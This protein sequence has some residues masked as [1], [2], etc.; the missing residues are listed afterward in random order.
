[1]TVRGE[2]LA[3]GICFII[4]VAYSVAAGMWAVLWTDLVQFVI[5]M[6]A[7]I[8]LA[9]FAVRAVGG[10]DVM[11]V[12]SWRT[13]AAEKRRS[14]CCRCSLGPPSACTAYAWMPLLT[15]GVYLSVQWWAAWYPGAEPGGGG[16]IAQR[17]FSAKTERDGVL[18]TL[19]FNIAHYA[20]RPWP[21]IVTGTRDGD[22]L[23]DG[24]QGQGGRL[25]P[26]VRGPAA[27]SVARIHA[28]GIC[29]RVH[30]HGRARSSTGARRISSTTSTSVS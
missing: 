9:V 12:N 2:V 11:K 1:M 25:R 14:R 28:G 24:M 5:K 4:T 26:G 13:S 19:F 7:V 3:V 6:T 23:P 21:W 29:G 22:S 10:I 15:L 30:V 20:L 18:A 17:I 27:D 16:Y 8:I